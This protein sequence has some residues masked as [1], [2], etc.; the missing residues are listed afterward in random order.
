M[1]CNQ[2]VSTTLFKTYNSLFL[3]STTSNKRTFPKS[4]SEIDDKYPTD[5][6]LFQAF[7]SPRP[8]STGNSQRLSQAFNYDRQYAYP[9]TF[10]NRSQ[11]NR[12]SQAQKHSQL[13]TCPSTGYDHRRA[14]P[15]FGRDTSPSRR[16]YKRI[17]PLSSF[18]HSSSI[19]CY[20]PL[21]Y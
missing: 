12:T 6:P 5:R 14:E 1:Y 17:A 8:N 19:C 13:H 3:Y 20:Q 2:F 16:N 18:A 4:I 11:R 15:N 10:R 9:D 7:G 21:I